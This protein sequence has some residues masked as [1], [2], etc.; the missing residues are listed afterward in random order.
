MNHLEIINYLIKKN[1]YKSYLEIGIYD[2]INFNNVICDNKECCDTCECVK[3]PSCKVDYVMTSDEMFEKM[4][5]DKKYDIIFIDGMHDESYVDRDIMNSM[6]HLNKD[7][8]ICLHDVIPTS[9][10]ITKKYDTYSDKRGAWCGDVYK[11]MLKLKQTNL[12]YY[13]VNNN[14]YGFGIIKYNKDFNID[15]TNLKTDYKFNDIFITDLGKF[16]MNI[17]TVNEFKKIFN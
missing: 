1:N 9:E 12:E 16:M 6:K 2:G 5:N 7:G 4:S 8:L 13:T 14:D 3:N 17:I 11:S 15:L 10:I